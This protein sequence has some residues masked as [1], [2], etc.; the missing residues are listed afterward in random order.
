L[1]EG[2]G[3]RRPKYTVYH[4]DSDPE[5][6]FIVKFFSK[7]CGLENLQEFSEA[8]EAGE[9]P[10]DQLPQLVHPQAGQLPPDRYIVVSIS[11]P[12]PH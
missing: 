8:V 2:S 1:V 7:G 11:E 12:D 3:F 9:L 6:C 5:H 4:T 10:W